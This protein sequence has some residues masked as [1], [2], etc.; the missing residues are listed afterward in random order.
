MFTDFQ[1]SEKWNRERQTFRKWMR[2][3]NI[4]S[5]MIFN[6]LGPCFDKIDRHIGCLWG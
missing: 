5:G 6:V 4:V 1:A 2:I 3:R